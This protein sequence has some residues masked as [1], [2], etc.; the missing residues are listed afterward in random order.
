M[1]LCLHICCGP[2]AIVPHDE[3]L[4]E[5]HYVRGYFFNPNIHPYQEFATRLRTVQEFAALVT[6]P[7]DVDETYDLEMCLNGMMG[8]EGDRCLACYRMRLEKA[9]VHAKE[10]GLEGLTSTLLYSRYQRHDDIRAIGEELEKT[11]D[12]PFLY[13]DFRKGWN[14]GIRKSKDLKMYRQQYCG[15]I[16]SEYERYGGKG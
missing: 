7:L 12:L 4:R 15:C 10:Q 14:D 5:G 9:F 2:C 1:N 11:Y 3:L 6:M 13:R 16:F 8:R